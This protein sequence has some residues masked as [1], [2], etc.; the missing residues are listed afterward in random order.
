MSFA[1]YIK[2]CRSLLHGVCA[3]GSEIYQIQGRHVQSVVG[4]LTLPGRQSPEWDDA[5]HGMKR[6]KMTNPLFYAR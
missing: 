3:R 4:S 6:K 1:V 2:R 5:V